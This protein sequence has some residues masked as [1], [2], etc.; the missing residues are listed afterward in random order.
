[1]WG[2]DKAFTN[3]TT[4]ADRLGSPYIIPSNANLAEGLVFSMVA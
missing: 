4:L 2:I 3:I 1:M